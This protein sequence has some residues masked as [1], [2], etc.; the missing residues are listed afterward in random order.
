MSPKDRPAKALDV[1]IRVSQVRGREGDAFQ[2]PKQQ[3]DRCRKQLDADGLEVGEVLVDLDESGGKTSRPAF[4]RALERARSGESGG[5]IVHD[6]SRFGR[7]DSMARDIIGLEEHGATFISC[8]EKIDTTT[9]N[10]RFFL[11]VMEAMVVL[12]REQ[13]GERISVAQHNAV[14]R[15]V[16]VSRF[17][18]AGYEKDRESGRLVPHPD[19]GRTIT[20][21]YRMAADGESPSA[22][23]RYLNERKLASGNG[24]TVWKASR[25]KRLLANPVYKGQAR[26]G[27]IVNNEAHEPLVDETTWLLAQRKQASSP[28]PIREDSE[29]I[30]SGFVRCASCRFAMRSQAARGKTIGTYRCA[31]ETAMGRCEQ[32]CSIS[33]DRLDDLVFRQFI[34]REWARL[35]EPRDEKPQRVEADALEDLAAANENLREVQA[36]KGEIRDALYYQAENEALDRV[37]EAQKRVDALAATPS[38]LRTMLRARAPQVERIIAGERVLAVMDEEAVRLL[39]SDLAKE[40]QAVFVRPAK[41][42]SNKAP[43][44]DRVRLIWGEDE[45]PEVPRR[46]VNFTPTPYIFPDESSEKQVA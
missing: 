26:Y 5:I 1:Y 2:S 16:H 24:Q 14:A 12:Q 37:D 40:L 15:G 18:P 23:A 35:S 45:M 31:T 25:I 32:P 20:R 3:E 10:G 27:E 43:L 29:Y 34:L 8:A 38:D 19:H 46:G 11:K 30:L 4:D 41:T 13:I 44:E 39:R 33:M 36:L 7:Y 42:R 17:A 21:A 22:I 6:L 28:T 9:S